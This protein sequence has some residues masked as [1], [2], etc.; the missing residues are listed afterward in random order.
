MKG[1]DIDIEGT[2]CTLEIKAL[3]RLFKELLTTLQVSESPADVL[4]KVM[5][6][7]AETDLETCRWVLDNFYDLEAYLGLIEKT[8]NFAT[9]ILIE[10]GF[11]P[12]QDFS[13]NPAGGIL[14]KRNVNA[15]LMEEVAAFDCLLLED[16]LQVFG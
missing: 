2:T 7:L 16:I 5:Y 3:M 10:K 11:I 13:A 9:Q 1:L 6:Q 15:A 14:I 8:A 12:G 4:T